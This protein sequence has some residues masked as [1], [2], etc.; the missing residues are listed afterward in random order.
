MFDTRTHGNKGFTV[1]EIVIALA[2]IA[3]FITLPI[4][5]YTNY[6]KKSRDSQRK[7]D[8]GQIQYSLEQ[9]QDTNGVYPA[10]LEDLV[11]EGYLAAIPIDP[12]TK[13]PYTYG[14]N[15]DGTDYQLSGNLEDAGGNAAGYIVATPR[16]T[17]TG[18]GTPTPTVPGG[19]GGTVPTGSQ[20]VTN[21]P[22]PTNTPSPT[23][24]PTPTGIPTQAPNSWQAMNVTGNQGG[25]YNHTT[26]WTGSEMIVW[27]G[28]S[29]EGDPFEELSHG[30]IYNPA[31]DSWRPMSTVN[32]PAARMHAGR[33]WS[34]TEMI[35]FG[36]TRGGSCN[37]GTCIHNDGG[38]Y[39]P[40]TD[41]WT[42][43][44]TPP[45][46]ITVGGSSAY[47][48][49]IVS[50]NYYVFFTDFDSPYRQGGRYN[51]TTNTWAT[52]SKTGAI[53]RSDR[54]IASVNNKIYVW[55][56]VDYNY[57]NPI[58]Y[59]TGG[60]YDPATD[61]WTAMSTTNAP[62]AR[63]GSTEQVMGSRIFIWGGGGP[64]EQLL[65]TGAIYNTVT[66]SWTTV[67]TVNAPSPRARAHS[68][69][70]GTHIIIWGGI[71]MPWTNGDILGD[72][73]LYNPA[74]NTWTEVTAANAPAERYDYGMS[75]AWTGERFIIWGGRSSN[76]TGTPLNEGSLYRM[77]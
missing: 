34:G 3:V 67:S 20:F 31:T 6:M 75:S 11:Q 1:V 21:T 57:G 16:G 59:N 64:G 24:T 50:G 32:Q 77:P 45:S 29:P 47:S 23:R 69:W 18:G 53:S 56:G 42:P 49:S 54:A 40:T 70:T 27:S 14:S 61:T 25:R 33:G 68:A 41:T 71:G 60:V 4:F 7:N 62:S 5:A 8:I 65:N 51:L 19:G 39:N 58:Y 44:P 38:R 30:D 13:Q 66:N 55:G 74:T 35:V 12:L 36:G 73:H 15:A 17:T 46:P 22:V 72:M 10:S 26:V 63:S 2:L 28:L 9:Y 43:I 48:D 52:V 76:F 37:V